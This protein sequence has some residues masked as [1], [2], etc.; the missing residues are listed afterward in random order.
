MTPE[1]AIERALPHGAKRAAL[2]AVESDAQIRSLEDIVHGERREREEKA[3][4]T[5]GMTFASTPR[6]CRNS[7]I[8]SPPRPNTKGSPILRRTTFRPSI[9]ASCVQR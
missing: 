1:E 2:S 5:P 4:D 3:A 9:T 6:L 7:S 8:S